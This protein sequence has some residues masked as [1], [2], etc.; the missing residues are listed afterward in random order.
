MLRF[1]YDSFLL[2]VCSLVYDLGYSH[3][4]EYNILK[5]EHA[6]VYLLLWFLIIIFE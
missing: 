4:S 2:L 3:C 6:N 5:I 1:D